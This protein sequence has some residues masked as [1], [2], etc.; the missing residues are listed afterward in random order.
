MN[1]HESPG[2]PVKMFVLRLRYRLSLDATRRSVVGTR[3]DRAHPVRSLLLEA[4]TQ[5]ITI[6]CVHA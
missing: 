4:E 3:V 6:R 1:D 5:V 2:K